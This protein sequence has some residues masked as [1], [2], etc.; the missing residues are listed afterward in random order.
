M[1]VTQPVETN[2]DTI[3]QTD[4]YFEATLTCDQTPVRTTVGPNAFTTIVDT[5]GKCTVVKAAVVIPIN[6]A[7]VGNDKEICNY[8]EGHSQAVPVRNG[9]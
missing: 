6:A 7:R 1:K 5:T 3:C 4:E 9:Q 2:N 8:V